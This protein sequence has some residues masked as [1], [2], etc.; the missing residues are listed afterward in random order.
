MVSWSENRAVKS[1]ESGSLLYS[2]KTLV[3]LL[4]PVAIYCLPW[5]SPGLLL[6]VSVCGTA[7]SPVSVA[8]VLWLAISLYAFYV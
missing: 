8:S 3:A 2:S 4:Y 1:N 6:N 5:T 7:K